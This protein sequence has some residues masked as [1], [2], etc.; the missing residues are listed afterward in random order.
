MNSEEPIDRLFSEWMEAGKRGDVAAVVS[1][2]TED[3]EFC[4]VS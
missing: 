3:A 2:V 4:R 1:L